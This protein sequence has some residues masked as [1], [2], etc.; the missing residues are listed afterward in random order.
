MSA[1]PANQPSIEELT[2]A[3]QDKYD[4]VL[5]FSANFKHT[6]EGGVLRTTLTEHGTVRVKKPGMMRWHYTEPEEKYFVSNG[7]TL[8][9]HIPLDR[10]VFIEQISTGDHSSTPALF[11][12]GKIQI[13]RE[14]VVTY[15]RVFNEPENSWI[16]RLT[17]RLNH[18]EYEWLTLAID[19]STLSIIQLITTDFQGGISSFTFTNINENQDLEDALFVFD[20][21]SDTEVFNAQRE[22]LR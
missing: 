3:L 9:S 21:P 2:K 20:I 11:L 14:F 16:L 22:E 10:K 4:S 5:D 15:D 18:A 17:P 12:A 13:S 8:Y 7:E 19:R 1:Q 6:Y